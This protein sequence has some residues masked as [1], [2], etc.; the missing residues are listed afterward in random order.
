[1]ETKLALDVAGDIGA[2]RKTKPAPHGDQA[3]AASSAALT[4]RA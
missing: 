2:N 3:G 1:V 4:A